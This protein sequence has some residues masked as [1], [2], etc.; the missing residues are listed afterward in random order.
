MDSNLKMSTVD[1]RN[2]VCFF[3]TFQ[4]NIDNNN[5]VW[6]GCQD[7]KNAPSDDQYYHM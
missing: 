5:V 2:N 7:N 1:E 4:V 3:F 6:V